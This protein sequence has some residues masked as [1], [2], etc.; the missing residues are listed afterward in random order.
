MVFILP[1]F[2]TGN[3]GN[4]MIGKIISHYKILKKSVKAGW[5]KCTGLR[6]PG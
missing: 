2:I 1:V 3:E 6:T 4:N 5:E